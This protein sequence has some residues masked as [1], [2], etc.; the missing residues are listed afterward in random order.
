MVTIKM[1]AQRCGLSV[2]A[3]SKALNHQPGIS[4]EKA[5][6]VRQVAEEMR[7][8]PNAAARTLKTSRSN[9]IGVVFQNRLVH[10]YF[11]EILES[12]R[13]YM[14]KRGYDITFL[15]DERDSGM[16]VYEHAMQRQCDGV[17]IA[18]GSARA[19][20]DRLVQS[21]IPVV[22]IDQLFQGRT[23]VLSDNADSFNQI[24][25]YLYQMGHR[26]IA[27]IHGEDG[28][29]TRMRLAGFHRACRK[30]G[31]EVPEEY[32]VA[33]KFQE[34]KDSGLATRQLLA[35]KNR[36]TCILYPDDISY[37]G[38]ATEIERQGLSVPEDISCFGYDGIRLSRLLRPSLATYRQ[39]AEQIGRR[40]AEELLLAIE[41]PKCYVPQIV[42]VAGS[43]QPGDS[44][45][46]LN[47]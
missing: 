18:Q 37:L 36:P 9:N 31:L 39:D 27:M 32:V 21:D 46:D 1:V 22:A 47:Q 16:S 24:I 29:V 30:W 10:E 42:T 45:K 26:R 6:W 8:Y 11:S 44:V 23:A 17:L 40:A 28:E 25:D 41:D 7:Y 15:N 34:P 3:V 35:L 19:D 13:A 33:A 20:L 43:V 12:I 2:G 14:E 5:A 4:P 38:G